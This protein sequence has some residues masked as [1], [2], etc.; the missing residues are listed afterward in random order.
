MF[1]LM[2]QVLTV[3]NKWPEVSK[4]SFVAHSLGGLGARYA[5]GSLYENVPTIG[6]LGLNEKDA[7]NLER[8]Y[9]ARIAGLQPVS[10]ITVVTPHCGSRGHR[11]VS[12][13]IQSCKG[14]ILGW[15]GGL[16]NGSKQVNFLMVAIVGLGFSSV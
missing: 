3:V 7:H 5:I 16:G 2:L 10:F 9:E 12:F 6:S 4:I 15:L 13:L 14:G 1:F 11:Q 8:F